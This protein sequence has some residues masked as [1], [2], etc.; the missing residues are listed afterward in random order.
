MASGPDDLG[1][2][3]SREENRAF[4]EMAGRTKSSDPVFAYAPRWVPTGHWRMSGFDIVIVVFGIA[5][6]LMVL[7]MRLFGIIGG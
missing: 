5:L 6:I 7:G 4:R 2:A 1:D 3:R